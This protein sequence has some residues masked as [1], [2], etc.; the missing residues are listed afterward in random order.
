MVAPSNEG[1]QDTNSTA[2]S[3]SNNQG[4]SMGAKYKEFLRR[5]IEEPEAFWGEQAE[6]IDWH[7]PFQSAVR[8]MVRR[9]RDQPLLQ[10]SGP[11]SGRAWESE[12]ADLRFH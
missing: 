10:C 2:D 4:T 3:I 7:K 12:R 6:F 1:Q 8:K 5:S 9:R 11:A